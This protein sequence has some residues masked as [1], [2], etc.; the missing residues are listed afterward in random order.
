MLC[1]K[2]HGSSCIVQYN[3]SKTCTFLKFKIIFLV[4]VFW[5]VTYLRYFIYEKPW[6]RTIELNWFYWFQVVI[7]YY[8][9]AVINVVRLFTSYESGCAKFHCKNKLE[10]I[11]NWLENI[12]VVKKHLVKFSNNWIFD[13]CSKYQITV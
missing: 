8:L 5:I 3:I 6:N 13:L 10:N 2:F 7:S 4:S 9:R 12:A 11:G 1:I